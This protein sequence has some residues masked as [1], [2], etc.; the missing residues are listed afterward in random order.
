MAL[1]THMKGKKPLLV[2]MR[3]GP[4]PITRAAAEE[5]AAA[6]EAA[7]ATSDAQSSNWTNLNK[8]NLK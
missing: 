4:Q 7:A 1:L 8:I 6:A 2:A 3:A 5:A